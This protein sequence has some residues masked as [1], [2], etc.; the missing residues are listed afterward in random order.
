MN[1]SS[2]VF[3]AGHRGLVGSALARVLARR[4]YGD[5]IT[6]SHEALDLGDAGAVAHF[7][8]EAKPEVI[9]LA[10][11]RV[12][13]I[14][15][16][17]TQPADF[18]RD[19]L[20]IETSVIHEA[21]MAGVKSLLFFGSSCM[22]PREASQPI[23]ESALMTGPLE[24]TSRPYGVAKIAGTE[25]CW[26]YNRQHATRFLCAVPTGIYGPG[27]NYDL[28]AG[29]VIPA[30]IRRFHEA[31]ERG[32]AQVTLWGTGAP[33]REFLH[34]DDLAAACIHLMELPPDRT[35]SLFA[36]DEPPLVN[37]GG[38]EELSIREL[39]NCVRDVV[40]AAIPIVWDATKPDGTPRKALDSRRLTDL[41]WG[42]SISFGAGLRDAYAEFLERRVHA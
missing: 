29:H 37:I 10:A 5:V 18:I 28:Q 33:R 6:R 21:A 2:R 35:A 16:N 23:V 13:G 34:C 27:D 9:F 30:L 40:G 32:D 7:L 4:G 36:A 26:A 41:G 11:A 42:P 17:D 31:K 39:A 19:N 25:L 8:A 24:P 14:L 3:I 22:Y 20:A 1:R 12:G 15:A 38:G